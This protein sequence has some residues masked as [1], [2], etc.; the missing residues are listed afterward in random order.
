[1]RCVARIL[2]LLFCPLFLLAGCH[3]P[4][5]SKSKQIF[6]NS[7]RRD[8]DLS[9]EADAAARRRI[10]ELDMGCAAYFVENTQE[11]KVILGSADHCADYD[12]AAW[13]VQ[14]T[15]T[16][17]EGKV[18][19]C[20]RIIAS[21][22]GRDI[23]FF[24]AKYDQPVP[25][26]R[27][28]RLTAYLPKINTRLQ[29]LGF[30]A[31]IRHG[32]ATLTENCWIL[33]DSVESI[34]THD[35][36]ATVDPS[37]MHNCSTY[38][39][40]SGGPMIIEGT[41]DVIGLPSTYQ[42]AQI[43]PYKKDELVAFLV[44]MADFVRLKRDVLAQEKIVI[45]ET[46]PTEFSTFKLPAPNEAEQEFIKFCQD[47][48]LMTATE[49]QTLRAML[50][51]V[52]TDDCALG[53]FRLHRATELSLAD[54]NL[55][56]ISLL[57][58]DILARGRIRALYIQNNALT[59][60]SPLHQLRQLLIVNASSNA[61]TT[62]PDLQKLPALSMLVLDNN[63]LTNLDTIRAGTS[64]SLKTLRLAGNRLVDAS[65]AKNLPLLNNLNLDRNT[66]D[67]PR[68]LQSIANLPQQLRKLSLNEME[69][70]NLDAIKAV[71]ISE[72]LNLQNNR[73]SGLTSLKTLSS[74]ARIQTLDLSGNPLISLAGI[75]SMAALKTLSIYNVQ[76]A[77]LQPLEDLQQLEEIDLTGNMAV[78]DL[79]PLDGLGKLSW[80]YLLETQI[81]EGQ[82]P[83]Q[84]NVCLWQ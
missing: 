63:Q 24:E 34:H 51:A 7:I 68:L 82:C 36:P 8:F 4:Q 40:N 13:C 83:L 14:G 33:S 23:F 30:P 39:G 15:F 59:D 11:G 37:Q 17:H 58:L 54:H 81:P 43:A 12:P 6:E 46:E 2:I 10:V 57:Q 66:A 41:R 31:D 20:Q 78:T 73:L 3:G 67:A 49:A 28:L 16:D 44:S 5:D 64:S 79:S 84:K 22:P 18:G 71:F 60:L 45:S 80:I 19:S 29:M 65:G 47:P 55:S 74:A 32:M 61:L 21:E 1:M 70:D 56:E 48:S 75:E 77:D 38:G 9:L 35:N 69:L 42:P 25:V 53:A 72:V 62:M 27:T 50:D 26:E 52:S 76:V